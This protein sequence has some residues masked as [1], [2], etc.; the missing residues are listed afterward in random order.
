[1]KAFK[2]KPTSPASSFD[3]REDR[4]VQRTNMRDSKENIS[5]ESTSFVKASAP[6]NRSQ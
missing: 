2:K 6:I 4:L 1:V 3:N 5:L